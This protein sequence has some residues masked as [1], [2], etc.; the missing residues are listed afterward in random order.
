MQETFWKEKSKNTKIDKRQR[1]PAGSRSAPERDVSETQPSQRPDPQCPWVVASL[2][3]ILRHPEAFR[4]L[5]AA[6]RRSDCMLMH[7]SV[8]SLKAG[9][10]GVAVV[11]TAV[12]GDVLLHSFVGRLVLLHNIAGARASIAHAHRTGP[13]DH[14][15]LAVN[16]HLDLRESDFTHGLGS[17]RFKAMLAKKAQKIQAPIFFHIYLQAELY[18]SHQNLPKLALVPVCR[19]PL[20]QYDASSVLLS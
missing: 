12:A 10:A 8:H 16:Q 9:S 1:R 14:D 4:S 7:G 5:D 17:S 18:R 19:F 11:S 3:C 20:H 13:V 2:P 15:L 6:H